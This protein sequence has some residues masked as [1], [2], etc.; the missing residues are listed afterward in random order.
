VHGL[1]FVV[2]GQT[3]FGRP[4][5]HIPCS[6]DRVGYFKILGQDFREITIHFV[7]YLLLRE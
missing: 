6:K 2:G 7:A 4:S 5:R 3:G 1:A